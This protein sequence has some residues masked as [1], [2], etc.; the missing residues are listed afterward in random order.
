MLF[1]P[2]KIVSVRSA[3]E[4][5]TYEEG[6]DYVWIAGDR[7]IRLNGP[8]RLNAQGEF[9]IIQNLALTGVLDLV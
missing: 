4:D 9:V 7:V 3:S 1:V 8:V 2:T 5:V 6:R